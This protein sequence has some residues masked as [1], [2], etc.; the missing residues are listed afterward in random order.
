MASSTYPNFHKP[1]EFYQVDNL[2]NQ[3][4]AIFAKTQE[5]SGKISLSDLN[6]VSI[7]AR[8]VA[9]NNSITASVIPKLTAIDASN[10]IVAT[11]TTAIDTS[12]TAS[13]IPKLTAIDA[14]NTIVATKTTAID[15][16]CTAISAKLT[17]L[18]T[19]LKAMQGGLVTPSATW[20]IHGGRNLFGSGPIIFRAGASRLSKL[21]FQNFDT[22][23]VYIVLMDLPSTALTVGQSIF[24]GRCYSFDGGGVVHLDHNFWNEPGAQ[25][26]AGTVLGLLFSSGL[27]IG[28]STSPETWQPAALTSSFRIELGGA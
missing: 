8:L 12:I 16:S 19:N 15:V 25:S 6:L 1:P 14:S 2:G 26:A 24:P 13:V 20:E 3:L 22:T 10:T 18:D 11:K 28:L 23:R 4:A 7:D 27:W 17:T 9:S 21:F 5:I